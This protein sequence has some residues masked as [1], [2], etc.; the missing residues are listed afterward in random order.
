[1]PRTRVWTRSNVAGSGFVMPTPYVSL[2][3]DFSEGETLARTRI[4][5]QMISL[6]ISTGGGLYPVNFI[7]W[8]TVIALLW[9]QG[10]GGVPSPP[11]GY[12]GFEG[13]PWIWAQNVSWETDS[14]VKGSSGIPDTFYGRNTAESRSIDCRSQR[15]CQPGNGAGLWLIIDTVQ[16]GGPDGDGFNISD[17]NYGASVLTIEP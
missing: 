15:L 5:L 3:R 9:E 17:L 12:F 16:N 13:Y 2:L 10:S 8:N 11:T 14:F 6:A 1:M 7:G 4:D